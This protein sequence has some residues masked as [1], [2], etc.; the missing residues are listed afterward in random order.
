MDK[1]AAPDHPIHELL[2]RRW[3]PRAFS[4]HLI[5]PDKIHSLLEAARWSAS[6]FNE[7]PWSFLIATRDDE[8]LFSKAVSCL[9]EANQSWAQTAPLLILTTSKKSF[10]HNNKPNRVYLHDLG[11]AIGSLSL[12]ATAMGL[13]LHQMAG[14]DVE[15]I[16]QLYDVPPDHDPITAIAVGYPGDPQ[17][18]PPKIREIEQSPRTRKSL[19]EFVFSGQ[20]GTPAII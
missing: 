3:S 17:Q 9:F 8:A 7:Q 20:F 13:A 19:S 1:P 6:S 11:L 14:V 10:S 4:D 18:L 15:K 2:V 5:E 12:Q 16:R